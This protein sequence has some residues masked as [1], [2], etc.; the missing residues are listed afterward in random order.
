MLYGQLPRWNGSTLRA[1]LVEQPPP[2]TVRPRRASTYVLSER[3]V[4]SWA[5]SSRLTLT[6]TLISQKH[7]L[8]PVGTL[9]STVLLQRTLFPPL[10][11]HCS[12]TAAAVDK[13]TVGLP[14]GFLPN[15]LAIF[16]FSS[17]FPQSFMFLF[18]FFS[19]LF[20]EYVLSYNL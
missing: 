11:N 5:H 7:F 17:L 18:F 3:G 6:L 16:S 9:I 20:C 10:L 13:A 4:N 2:L 15:Y 8:F 14:Q 12:L 1:G 19:F